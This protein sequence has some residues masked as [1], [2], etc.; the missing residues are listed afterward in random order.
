[1]PAR[2]NV[3]FQVDVL[4]RLWRRQLAAQPPTIT[5]AQLMAYATGAAAVVID[6]TEVIR[7]TFGDGATEAIVNHPKEVV[8]KAALDILDEIDAGT[9]PGGSTVDDSV[10]HADLSKTRIET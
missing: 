4:K 9:G 6:G 1:M 7:V 5:E 2:E 10:V 8:I 3:E